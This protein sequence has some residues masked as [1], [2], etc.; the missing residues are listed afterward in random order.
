[1]YFRLKNICLKICYS[2]TTNLRALRVPKLLEKLLLKSDKL[3]LTFFAQNP[4]PPVIITEI[5]IREHDVQNWKI[6]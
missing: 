4:V 1:M 6:T 5:N 2:N 3:K